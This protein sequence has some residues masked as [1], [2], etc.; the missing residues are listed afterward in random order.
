VVKACQ[1]WKK[2]IEKGY[3]TDPSLNMLTNSGYLWNNEKFGM[4]L[5]GTWYY[6]TVLIAQ[7]VDEK[8]IGA[9]IMPPHNPGAGKNIIIEV[10]PIFTAKHAKNA[11]AALKV[12]DW[13]M[14]PQ[15]SGYFASLQKGYPGS[16]KTDTSYLPP[17]KKQILAE[18]KDGQYRLMNRYWEATPE[19]ICEQGVLKLGEFMLNPEKLT[20][21][22]KDIERIADTYWAGIPNR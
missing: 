6:Y 21:V 8:S 13:W 17:V 3:F 19:P 9:F 14:S 5:C 15:G 12:V 11:E 2:M 18:I 16:L 20:V 4:V 10:G 1:V 7:G 22:L